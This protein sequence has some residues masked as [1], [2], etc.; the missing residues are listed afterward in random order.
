MATT[1]TSTR[2]AVL[3]GTT[4]ALPTGPILFAS[5]GSDSTEPALRATRQLAQ[6]FQ[7]EV[8]VVGVVD[9]MPPFFVP[10]EALVQ[11]LE[12]VSLLVGSMRQRVTTQLRQ[13]LGERSGWHAEVRRGVPSQ[14]IA[15]VSREHD[16]SLI[17]TGLSPHPV[18]DRVFGNE[19]P[20]ELTRLIDRPLLAVAPNWEVMPR[21]LVITVDMSGASERVA[22]LACSLFPEAT[23]VYLVHVMPKLT[24]IEGE[25]PDWESMYERELAA[26]YERIRAAITTNAKVETVTLHGSVAKEITDF[27]EY[28]KADLIVTGVHTHGVFY[29]LF[30]GNVATKLLRAATTSVLLVPEGEPV[31]SPLTE[32]LT[33]TLPRDDWSTRLRDFTLRNKGRRVTLE[34][35]EPTLG[36]IIQAYDYPFLG[37]SYDARDRRV[38]LLLGEGV[39]DGRQ[40]T[41]TIG[42]PTSIDILSA[43]RGRD[44]TLRI[45]YEGGQALL[46]FLVEEHQPLWTTGD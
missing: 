21:T 44:T 34:I 3:R 31:E 7:R 42:K 5:D 23:T 25:V 30:F 1:T 33:T 37:V 15:A 24:E 11:P 19:V 8:Q 16:A 35:D 17:V 27:A 2:P 20:V 45:A 36:A 40:F 39:A 18:V 4:A 22:G 14:T 10:P 28:A 9:A 38:Q 29:R 6:R 12:S 41:H 46:N 26:A 43:P 13:D 32:P